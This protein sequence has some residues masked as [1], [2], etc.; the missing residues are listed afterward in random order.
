MTIRRTALVAALALAATALTGCGGDATDT[1]PVAGA[2]TDTAAQEVA[3]PDAIAVT[4]VTAPLN[5]PSITERRIGAFADAFA[6]MGV[7]VTYA[8]LTTGPEQTAALASGDIQFL[9]AVG[10]TSVILAAANGADV[11]IVDMYSR[12][13]EAFM[14]ITGEDG[15]TSAAELAGTTVAGPKGTILHELLLA[16]LATAGLTADDIDFVDMTIPDAQAAL[17]GGSVDVALQAGPAAY[18]MLQQGYRTLTDGTGLVGASIVVA[19]SRT[20]ADAYPEVVARFVQAH[21]AVLDHMAANEDEVLA[22]AAE[23]TGLSAEAVR[24]MYAMYDFSLEVTD[25]DLA[26]MA[27]TQEFMLAN[28]MIEQP[29]D[30]S[31]LVLT[32]P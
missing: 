30:L 13:P 4:Y 9:F 21:R 29:V 17:V 7:D 8:E 19:T 31:G 26:D 32:L 16:Y 1:D 22:M 18:T 3:A 12:S 23:E 11:A 25:A 14:L 6:D 10:A 20:F 28:G 15:P 27:A 5:V 2:T 24:E